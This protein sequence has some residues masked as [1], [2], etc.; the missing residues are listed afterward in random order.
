MTDEFGMLS[1]NAEEVG[2]PW[3]CHPSSG[4]S[5]TRSVR[6]GRSVPFVGEP[7]H[8]GSCTCTS[9][10]WEHISATSIPLTLV[11]GGDSRFVADAD[12][13]EF[14][15]RGPSASVLVVPGAGHAV[16]SDQPLHLPEIIRTTAG[17]D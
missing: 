14:V 15:R 16:Q 11:R 1:E 8:P 5:P 9:P 17:L 7:T 3:S 10:L 4:G 12:A 6:D 2:L 13:E